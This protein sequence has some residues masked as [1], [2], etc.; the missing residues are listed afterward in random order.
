MM[1]SGNLSPFQ[2]IPHTIIVISA[3]EV[4]FDID[5]LFRLAWILSNYSRADCAVP[6]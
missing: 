4:G 3:F 5:Y 2:T 6:H 1:S